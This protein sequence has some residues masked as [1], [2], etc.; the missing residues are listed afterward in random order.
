MTAS[1]PAVQDIEEHL[2]LS[3]FKVQGNKDTSG[4]TTHQI[5]Q[6]KFDVTEFVS[7]ISEK[8]IAHSKA[9]NGRKCLSQT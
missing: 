9:E 6:G 7:S 4:H 2:Q 8:L 3:A 1:S 5:R